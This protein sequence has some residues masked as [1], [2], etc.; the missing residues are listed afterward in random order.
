ME[1]GDKFRFKGKIW[2]VKNTRQDYPDKVYHVVD[3]EGD[4]DT[5]RESHL[6]NDSTFKPYA[7]ETSKKDLLNS[8][9]KTLKEILELL[10]KQNSP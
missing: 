10:K 8:I 6:L 9:D 3:Q 4:S 5:F 2:T 7:G 1:V